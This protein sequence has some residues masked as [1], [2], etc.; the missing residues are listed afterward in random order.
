MSDT[1]EVSWPV[2]FIV[3]AGSGVPEEMEDL[4]LELSEP[5]I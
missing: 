4:E 2:D 1:A 3:A 5:V